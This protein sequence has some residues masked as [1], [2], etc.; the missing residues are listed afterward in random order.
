MQQ[1]LVSMITYCY[2]GE[3]FVHKYFEALLAQ[4]YQN[5]ELIFFNNGSVDE[6]GAIAE[7]YKPLLEARGI[8]VVL[9]HFAENQCTCALK[10]KGFDLM[11]GEYF[12]GC[13]SDDFIDPSYIEQMQGYLQAHP[14]K[15]I[16]FCPLRVVQEETGK[17]IDTL[18][19]TQ[20]P[21]VRQAFEDML[22]AR[23]SSFTA[24][25]YMISRKHYERVNPGMQIY[26]SDFGENYQIQLPLLYQD[27]QGYID[28]PLG[29]YTVRGDSYTG[30]MK[31]DPYKQVA[32][33]RGQEESV[34]ATLD[35]FLPAQQAYYCMIP[36][37]R[38]R[39][40]RLNAAMNCNNPALERECYRDLKAVGGVRLR[41]F[42]RYHIKPLRNLAQRRR[43]RKERKADLKQ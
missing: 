36:V 30:K 15:G 6:T 9:E 34:L 11:H 4:S 41:D 17:Q 37:K 35:K 28:H 10:Q 23:N 8:R 13:D 21:G 31:K 2:N 24:I 19:I 42:A 29:Q 25:S 18:R 14:E 1:P 43:K 26:I 40:E 16:V 7:K 27:L 33:F 5:I 20:K 22:Y 39:R 12:F 38:L 3:R 32:A